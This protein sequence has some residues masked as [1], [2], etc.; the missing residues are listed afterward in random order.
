MEKKK[1]IKSP[2]NYTGGKYKLLPV[3]KP[4]FP[5]DETIANFIDLFAGGANIAVNVNA[6]R[7]IAN[8]YDASVIGIFEEMQTKTFEEVL[9]WVTTRIK[10]YSLSMEN[11]DG[12]DKFR[13][14]Y[15]SSEE[16]YPL[17]LFVLICYSFNHQIRFN[18][19]G[20]FNMPF[21]KDRSQFNKSIENN[22][23]DF[24]EALH[25][26]N[27]VL[28]H[29]DFSDI[30][31]DKLTTDDFVYCDPPYLI[32]CASYNEQDGWN[33]TNE[34]KLLD[35]LD[36][37][38]ERGIRFALSNVLTNKGNTN[39]ILKEWSEKY[40]VHHLSYTYS[41]CSYHAKDRNKET[42]DEVLITNYD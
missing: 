25:T 31:L 2:L 21:G 42:T 26:K 40:N 1:F 8:D 37:L 36:K 33:E 7:I 9:E 20:E 17:D 15:N 13:S 3:I 41:N 11:K 14:Y 12:Y 32:T 38:N 39:E 22:L 24:C 28:T 27:I 16:K 4:L 5:K 19:K 34:R 30:K 35:L 18:K 10:Q 6:K 23:R 29:K